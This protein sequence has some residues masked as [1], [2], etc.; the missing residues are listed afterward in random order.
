MGK[1]DHQTFSSRVDIARTIAV[2][3]L[4]T[5]L[6]LLGRNIEACCTYKRGKDHSQLTLVSPWEKAECNYRSTLSL[7][8]LP[9]R[10]HNDLSS[11][12]MGDVAFRKSEECRELRPRILPQSHEGMF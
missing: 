3:S 4:Q 12:S 10:G 6:S 1:F 5:T 8:F 2:V 7:F 11:R 9:D